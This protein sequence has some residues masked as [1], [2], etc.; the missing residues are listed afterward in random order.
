MLRA[1]WPAVTTSGLRL[2]NAVNR[3]PSA[4][5][6]PAA[7]CKLTKAGR[8]VAWDVVRRYSRYGP[9]P[10]LPPLNGQADGAPLHIACVIP[11]FE[12]GSGGHN[13][14]LQMMYRLDLGD[15]RLRETH[16]P[17]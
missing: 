13:S 15:P 5:P 16:S 11:P 2:R 6:R 10:L 4:W 3:L 12:R 9:A 7:E 17:P 1:C 8:P 14:I